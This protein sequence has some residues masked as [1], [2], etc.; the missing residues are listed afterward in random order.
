MLRKASGNI[1]F[2]LS[3]SETIAIEYPGGTMHGDKRGEIVLGKLLITQLQRY[4]ERAQRRDRGTYPV[5]TTRYPAFA[6]G[7]TVKRSRP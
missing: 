1:I 2:S 6:A 4:R 7:L 5:V 3:V